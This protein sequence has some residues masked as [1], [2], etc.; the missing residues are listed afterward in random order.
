MGMSA[1]EEVSIYAE[2]LI[3]WLPEGEKLVLGLIIVWLDAGEAG[4]VT[5]F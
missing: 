3:A 4:L 2:G 5:M 1:F